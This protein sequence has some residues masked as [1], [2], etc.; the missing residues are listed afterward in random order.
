MI[1]VGGV[2]HIV[3]EIGSGGSWLR[4]RGNLAANN[5][6]ESRVVGVRA[7]GGG[8][9]DLNVMSSFGCTVRGSQRKCLS[10]RSTRGECHP[11]G[12]RSSTR[13]TIV[14]LDI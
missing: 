13:R 3:A 8:K 9:D 4:D 2:I 11:R 10:A 1:V 5:D 12:Q 7:I 6:C 14:I